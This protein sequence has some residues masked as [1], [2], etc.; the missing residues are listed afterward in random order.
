MRR[1]AFTLIELLVVIAIIAILI[2]LLLP[3]VQKVRAA[4]A[5]LKCQNNL[6]QI[7]LSLHNYHD[8]T[9]T[10][11]PGS[12]GAAFAN[13]PGNTNPDTPLWTANMGT[14]WAGFILPYVEQ[15]TVYRKLDLNLMNYGWWQT[16]SAS[17]VGTAM[18]QFYPSVF[19]C[20][21]NPVPVI[22]RNFIL[23][24]SYV[25]IAGASVDPGYSPPRQGDTRAFGPVALNGVM[26]VNGKIR[27]AD[28]TDGTTNVIVIGEQSDWGIDVAPPAGYP[29]KVACRASGHQ[30]QWG[31]SG[32]WVGTRSANIAT[33]T[34][35]TNTTTITDPLGT[36]TACH[37]GNYDY[38]GVETNAPNTPIRSAHASGSLIV[39]GDGSVR[40]LTEGIDTT[41]FQ[42]LAI[43]D[44][45]QVK[46][47]PGN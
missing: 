9:G 17:A 34:Q 46:T 7:G 26:I 3:A 31:G 29:S 44:S 6:K 22:Y 25:A 33:N 45:G 42:Y 16:G 36:R 24:N 20:P 2:G 43:R 27:I 23:Q 5:R 8:A 40:F 15:E 11:P 10:F 28:V 32:G 21:S 41:L 18:N 37:I 47:I 38:A 14:S 30:S 19:I 4:A 1:V 12:A 35:A 39:F 13:T